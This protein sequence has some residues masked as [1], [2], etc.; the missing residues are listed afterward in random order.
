MI[1]SPDEQT[2]A[3]NRDAAVADAVEQYK[4]MFEQNYDQYVKDFDDAR[5]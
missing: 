4:R 5:G 2:Y 1:R 3:A